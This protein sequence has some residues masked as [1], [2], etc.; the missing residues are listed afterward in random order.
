MPN[1]VGAKRKPSSGSA[2]PTPSAL[3][4]KAVSALGH[5]RIGEAAVR[6]AEKTPAFRDALLKEIAVDLKANGVR[7]RSP[8]ECTQCHDYFTPGVNRKDGEC[9]FHDGVAPCLSL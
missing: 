6:L 5:A 4:T 3:F 7:S 9:S 1:P 2:L 8:V